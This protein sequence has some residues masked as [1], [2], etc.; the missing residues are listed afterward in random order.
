MVSYSRKDSAIARKLIEEFKKIELDVWVDWEDIPPA[1][2]WLNQVLR[3]IEGSDAFIFIVSPDSVKSEIC[4][5]EVEHAAKNNK[6]II[7]IVV[8]DVDAKTVTPVIRDIN[9]IFIREQDKFEDGIAK[10]KIAI[11]LDIEWVE[12]HRRL[13]VRALEWERGKD[14]SLHLRGRDLRTASRMVKAAVNKDPK[15]TELQRI[16]IVHSRRAEIRMISLWIVT[17]IAV[18]VILILSFTSVR[19]YP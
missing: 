15:P 3:G 7:P 8:R 19:P 9:W 4:M 2:G 11:N 10:V 12:E 1:V 5:E 6:R 13:Q 14:S 16:Y 18:L 17:T